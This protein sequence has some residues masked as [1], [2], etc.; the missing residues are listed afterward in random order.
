MGGIIG[1]ATYMRSQEKLAVFNGPVGAGT[2]SSSTTTIN[3]QSS[4]SDEPTK[5]G[6]LD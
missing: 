6:R 1:I 4:S 3:T 5:P 2:V